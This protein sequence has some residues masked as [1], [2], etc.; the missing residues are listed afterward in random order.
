MLASPAR[1]L[2]C[3]YPHTTK[4]RGILETLEDIKA[5]LIAGDRLVVIADNCSDD[6]AA[7]A[8][9]VGADVVERHDPTRIGKG[10]AL[11]FGLR[12]LSADPPQIVII[13]DADSRMSPSAID[14]LTMACARPAD[15]FK[16]CT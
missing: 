12:H 16:R 13:I 10:Y 7:L 6:T 11:D 4:S 2:R 14:R 3:S 5:Q 8:A 15:L 9:T 1:P